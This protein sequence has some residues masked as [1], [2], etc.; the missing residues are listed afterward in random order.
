MKY[1]PV[2]VSICFDEEDQEYFAALPETGETFSL[3]ARNSMEAER[4][5]KDTYP[6]A[7][8]SIA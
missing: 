1:L 2:D 8:I 4:E 7:I 3:R 6:A 5:V